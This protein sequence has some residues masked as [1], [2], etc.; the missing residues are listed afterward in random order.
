MRALVSASPDVLIT[1]PEGDER[2]LAALAALGAHGREPGCREPRGADPP[3]RAT[4]PPWRISASISSRRRRR[5]LRRRPA[6]PCSSPR[7]ARGARRGDRAPHPRGGARGR[8]VRP[9]GGLAARA[10]RC[11]SRLLRG[12]LRRAGIPAYFA[13]GARRPDPPAARCSRCSRARREALGAPL[14]RVPLARPGARPGAEARRPPQRACWVAPRATRRSLPD[15]GDDSPRDARSP[16]GG[17]RA[18]RADARR[19]RG[20]DARSRDPRRRRPPV[21]AG[22]LRAPWRW[23]RLL[24]DAAVIGGRD[25][26]RGG[27]PGS[28]RA[29]SCASTSCATTSRTRRAGAARARAR[30]PRAP[31]RVRAA[32]GRARSRALP[33]RGALGRVARRSSRRSPP[34]AL[35]EPE[36]VL[37]VLAELAPMAA[38]GPVALD[39]V[40]L[41]LRRARCATVARAAAGRRYGA[42]LRRR[43]RA[44]RGLAFDV[45]FVPGLAESIFPQKS[46]EDPLLLDAAARA[47]GAALRRRTTASQRERLRCASRSARPRERVVPLVPAPRL[48]QARPRVPSFYALEVPRA[49]RARSPAS[50]S[51]AR[52]RRRPRRGAPRLARAR[53]CPR[54]RSTRPST[55]SRCSRR[56]CAATAQTGRAAARAT[57]S[58]NPHLARALALALRAL[59]AAAGRRPTASSSSPAAPRRHPLA[60][61]ADAARP[62]RRRRSQN[63]AACPYRFFLSRRSA[64]ARRARSPRRSRSSTR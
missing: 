45:V 44:A 54:A 26:W 53:R 11:Y 62:S 58:A 6:R 39:E 2:T 42:R 25:R 10:R 32:A 64:A 47:L 50:T 46:R 51:C 28:R 8:P 60:L 27:S 12:A 17:S 57:C 19:R 29:A 55:T 20:A 36:R 15:D 41:V 23:E 34:R 38:V 4:A 52:A 63:F 61:A 40:R 49:P 5:R 33:A 3:G 24:V 21:L 9:H 56:C 22:T 30:R 7:P 35:R 18:L 16:A 31:P 1:V 59:A 37:G 13:R 43:A 48:A 14:R